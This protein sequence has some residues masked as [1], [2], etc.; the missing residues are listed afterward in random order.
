MYDCR[1]QFRIPPAPLPSFSKNHHTTPELGDLE[2]K[3][4]FK[5]LLY[6]LEEKNTATSA[7][8]NLSIRKMHFQMSTFIANDDQETLSTRQLFT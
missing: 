2:S 5:I 1:P 3:L 4:S 7:I 6:F 8:R